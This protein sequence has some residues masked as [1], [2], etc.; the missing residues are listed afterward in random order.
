MFVLGLVGREAGSK[1]FGEQSLN[2]PFYLNCVTLCAGVGA[3]R[4]VFL[5]PCSDPP[6]NS[7]ANNGLPASCT[8]IDTGFPTQGDLPDTTG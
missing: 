5:D 2:K 1:R 4:H 8:N 6:K 3:R 7:L